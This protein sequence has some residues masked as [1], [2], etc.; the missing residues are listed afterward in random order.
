MRDKFAAL[1]R[2]RGKLTQRNGKS[3]VYKDQLDDMDVPCDGHQNGN[4][5]GG[6]RGY[7]RRL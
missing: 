7:K 1:S 4:M 3:Y 5:A 2:Q 6:C